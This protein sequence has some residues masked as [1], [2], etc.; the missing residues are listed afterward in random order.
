MKDGQANDVIEGLSG[1]GDDY[2]DAVEYLR[3]QYDKPRLIHREHVHSI[4]EAPSLKEENW[5]ELRR[6]HDVLSR[7]LHAL[8]R[9][10]PYGPFVTALVELKLDQLT[11]FEWQRQSQDA[12]DMPHFERLLKFLDLKAQASESFVQG[13]QK[14]QAQPKSSVQLRSAYTTN[15]SST[16]N[17]DHLNTHCSCAKIHIPAM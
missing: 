15:V 11:M 3:G 12:T 6:L 5:R 9:K 14:R 4:V 7:H 8:N 1:S 2:K 17:V 10:D 13:T 16:C